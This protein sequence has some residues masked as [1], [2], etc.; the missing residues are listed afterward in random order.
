MRPTRPMADINIT[1]LVDVVLVLLVVFMITAP[2]LLNGIELNLPQTKEVNRLNLSLGQVVVSVTKTGD[3]YLGAQKVL[4]G[5]LPAALHHEM[6]HK[7]ASVLYL[8]ADFGL[9]YGEVAELMSF[10]KRQGI[11]QIALVTELEA[12]KKK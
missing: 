10:L 8:R 9:R 12:E 4:R 2:L 1:P 5:E 3:L 11:K 7:K 6:Q